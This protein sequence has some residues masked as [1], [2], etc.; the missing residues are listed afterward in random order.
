MKK[1]FNWQGEIGFEFEYE[2]E[3]ERLDIFEGLVFN[4]LDFADSYNLKDELL[5]YMNN[6]KTYYMGGNFNMEDISEVDEDELQNR[7]R[8]ALRTQRQARIKDIVK[9]LEIS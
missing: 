5:E 8:T 9:H 4:L 6:E 7:Y 1:Y 2:T 3:E